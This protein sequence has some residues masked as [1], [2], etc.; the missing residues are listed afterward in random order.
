MDKIPHV[1]KHA[2]AQSLTF[3]AAVGAGGVWGILNIIKYLGG[4][5]IIFTV[6]QLCRKLLS[7]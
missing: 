5:P 2:E 6:H 1:H 7:C 4:F 3:N